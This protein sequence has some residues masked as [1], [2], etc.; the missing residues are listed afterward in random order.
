M[1]SNN[2]AIQVDTTH[3]YVGMI[4]Q[5]SIAVMGYVTGSA[6]IDWTPADWNHF[7]LAG[8]I[9]V[10]QS[11]SLLEFE[12]GRADV[13]DVEN[14]AGTMTAFLAAAAERKKHSLD[15]TL[16][17]SYDNLA[18][19]KAQITRAGLSGW[20]NYYVANWNW[21]MDQAEAFLATQ[22]TAVAVQFASPS[23]NPRTILP[24]AKITLA[25]ANCDLSVK[26]SGW[27]PAPG[28]ACSAW[29]ESV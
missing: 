4:P 28:I 16:Y 18:D 9:R 1:A 13:G 24:G 27:F 20:V 19:A 2:Y 14:G 12:A 11:A 17:V 6:D 3:E 15:S 25:V 29:A 7:P 22:G 26:R 8:K 21:S 23:S 5:N 10:D